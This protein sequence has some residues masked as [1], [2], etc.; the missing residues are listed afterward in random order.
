[1]IM[2]T[3]NVKEMRDEPRREELRKRKGGGGKLQK[4]SKSGKP[5]ELLA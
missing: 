1:M 4:R 3:R 5:K 2:E